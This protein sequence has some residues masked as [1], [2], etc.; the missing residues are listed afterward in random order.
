MTTDAP[1]TGS[2]PE[3]QTRSSHDVREWL[4]VAAKLIGAVAIACVTYVGYNYQ[5]KASLTS[6]MNQREQAESELR[7]SMLGDLV[8]PIIGQNGATNPNS[9]IRRQLLLAEMVTLNFHDHFEFKPLLLE[10]DSRLLQ[11]NDQEGHDKIASD[12]RRVIDRQ[13]NMLTSID[14]TSRSGNGYEAKVTRIDLLDLE[15]NKATIKTYPNCVE[16]GNISIKKPTLA[17]DSTI[18]LTSPDNKICLLLRFLA[19]DYDK[20]IMSIGSRVVFLERNKARERIWPWIVDT[21]KTSNEECRPNMDWAKQ[22][23]GTVQQLD[24]AHISIFD[25][26]L[27]DNAKIMRDNNQYRYSIS[28]YDMGDRKSPI[29]LKLVWFPEGY[30]T[31]RERPPQIAKIL[32]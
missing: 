23:I 16:N 1:D 22:P 31:E 19:P 3:G 27:T 9:D 28:I 21:D 4:D 5:S 12:A 6:V 20:R 24:E 29:S 2:S 11:A 10:V 30:I 18:C 15:G 17:E 7:A 8:Q 32:K 13:I 26:P 14:G 25:F